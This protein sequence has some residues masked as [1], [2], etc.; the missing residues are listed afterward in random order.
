MVDCITIVPL[1]REEEALESLTV[2]WWPRCMSRVAKCRPC[3]VLVLEPVLP[4]L[5][6]IRRSDTSQHYQYTPVTPYQCVIGATLVILVE[7]AVVSWL[8]YRP[9][10]PTLDV[11]H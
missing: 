2:A 7:Q 8:V 4:V 10:S 6:W 3:F 9:P 11:L 1:A 5:G